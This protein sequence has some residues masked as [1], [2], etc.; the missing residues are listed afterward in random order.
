LKEQISESSDAEVSFP[1]LNNLQNGIQNVIGEL[2]AFFSNQN[3][4]HVTNAIANV[5]GAIATAQGAF[6]RRRS[7][8]SKAFGESVSA[9]EKA[10]LA[11]VQTLRD[12]Q[13][14]LQTE[15]EKSA[16]VLGEQTNKSAEIGQKMDVTS[17]EHTAAISRLEAAYQQ[18]EAK[19]Q[20]QHK[21]TFETVRN[22]LAETNEQTE[23]D[24]RQSL[25]RM[26][27][28]ES[29]ARNIIQIIGNIGVTGN[30][31]NRATAE[32]TNA[33]RWRLATIALFGIG[34]ALATAN[35][36]MNFSGSIDLQTLVIRFAIAVTITIPALYTAKESAR[37]RTNADSA[38][39]T[40]LELASLAPF[41][42]N[43]PA[44]ERDRIIASVAPMYFG[45]PI[46]Q[47]DVKAPIDINKLADAVANAAG[48]LRPAA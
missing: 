34:I 6:F 23:E 48:R 24:A 11:A 10:A 16:A 7:K 39:Q 33:D 45:R 37:H 13:A 27:A 36:V 21:E 14:K 32:E 8:N 41:L 12:Q 9:V 29:K 31:Q 47:H 38:K 43:L 2:N 35:L 22:T 30:Y 3:P 1:A 17:A 20:A 19:A 46:N 28:L 40:E 25:I 15:I 5:D 4:G 42:E 44:E 18:F 26:A